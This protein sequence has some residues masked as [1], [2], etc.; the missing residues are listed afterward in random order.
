MIL[1]YKKLFETKLSTD[2]NV[3]DLVVGI[4]QADGL[5]IHNH[6]GIMRKNNGIEFLNK[7]SDRLHN[8]ENSIVK[9]N[10]WY[11]N[12]MKSVKYFDNNKN[13]NNLPFYLSEE[14]CN[15]VSQDLKFILD[16]INIYF[17]E[18]SYIDVTNRNDTISC[19]SSIDY[20]KLK[21]GENP[22]TTKLRKNIRIGGFFKKIFDDSPALIEK[23]VNLYKFSYGVNKDNVQFK[24]AKGLDMSKWFLSNYYAS[25]KGTLAQSCMRYVR[26][27]KRLPIYTSN[28]NK[29]RML[30][31]LD[32]DNKLLGRALIWKLDYP[33]NLIYMDRIYYTSEFIKYLFLDY[34]KKKGFLIKEDVE[35]NNIIMKVYLNKDF[36]PPDKNP[37][38]DTFKYFVKKDMYLTNKYNPL[39]LKDC[40]EYIDHD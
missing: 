23:Y 17:S 21:N 39:K 12:T 14:F 25:D 5:D 7:F 28:P 9:D 2:I 18:I 30:Y 37:F 1:S 15:I 11:I 22:W 33:Q 8:L 40:W 6:I 29:V 36:G 24:I 31:L 19:L 26:S 32:F 27:Q 10:G 34:A 16:Y 3:G 13:G 20:R 38:M 4:G 35:K